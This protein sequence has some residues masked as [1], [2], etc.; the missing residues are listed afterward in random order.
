MSK[1]RPTSETVAIR[2]WNSVPNEIKK[3]V[4]NLLRLSMDRLQ[5]ILED[6]SASESA[7]LR[8]HDAATKLYKELRELEIKELEA[9][10]G[11]K[12]VDELPEEEQMGAIISLVANP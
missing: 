12:L 3:K 10:N 11:D 7:V 9:L 6:D 8:A 2:E 4:P 1:G 5:K